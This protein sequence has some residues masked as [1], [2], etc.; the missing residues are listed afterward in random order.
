MEFHN[1]LFELIVV[2]IL[3]ELL[4]E[5]LSPEVTDIF[6]LLLSLLLVVQTL[7]GSELVGVNMSRI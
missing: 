3:L 7:V 5:I 2:K 1:E 4:E 6:L